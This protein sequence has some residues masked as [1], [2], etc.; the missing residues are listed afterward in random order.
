MVNLLD[1]SNF[2]RQTAVMTRLIEMIIQILYLGSL[3]SYRCWFILLRNVWRV[4]PT[5][6]SPQSVHSMPQMTFLV[7]QSRGS[8][9]LEFLIDNIFVM[10][11]GRV[12][13]QTVG[14]PIW[15]PTADFFFYSYEAD[16]YRS[17]SRKT[18]RNQSNL[19]KFTFRYIIWRLFTK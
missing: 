14:I 10:F 12:F 15:V 13:Q 4:S 3:A 17:F 5:Y 11:S 18:K 8:N 7:E 16:F 9:M 1:D 2:H 6:K 19:L